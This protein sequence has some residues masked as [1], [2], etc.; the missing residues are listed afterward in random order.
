LYQQDPLEPA[1]ITCGTISGGRGYNIVADTVALTGTARAFSSTTR[2]LLKTRLCELCC[3]TAAAYG[4][5]IDVD[6][7]CETILHLFI[8]VLFSMLLSVL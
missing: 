2:E 6:Y 1:V 5:V 3:A 4:G 7:T 8:L